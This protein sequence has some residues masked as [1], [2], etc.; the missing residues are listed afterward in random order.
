MA[1]EWRMDSCWLLR[2]HSPKP[3]GRQRSE[4]LP[5]VLSIS[6]IGR[7]IKSGF[8]FLLAKGKGNLNQLIVRSMKQGFGDILHA[9]LGEETSLASL[10]G[11]HRLAHSVGNV[12]HRIALGRQPQHFSLGLAQGYTLFFSPTCVSVWNTH[13]TH[14][15]HSSA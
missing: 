6:L 15:L 3:C 5:E 12:I 13:N 2:K 9:Q 1:G 8:P 10:D 7:N 14:Y 4:I 11:I